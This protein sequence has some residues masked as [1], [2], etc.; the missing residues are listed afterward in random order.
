MLDDFPPKKP[1]N[2]DPGRKLGSKVAYVVLG[3]APRLTY[4][5]RCTLH[6]RESALRPPL[7]GV[8][9]SF[10]DVA[11]LVITAPNASPQHLYRL[12]RSLCRY[13]IIIHMDHHHYLHPQ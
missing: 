9:T 13:I 3:Q 2:L 10:S 12:D 4:L 11:A 8:A 7:S 6:G 5:A 1:E